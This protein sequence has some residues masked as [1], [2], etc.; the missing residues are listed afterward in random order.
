MDAC[1]DIER[2]DTSKSTK[3]GYQSK[4]A[5]KEPDVALGTRAKEV[6]V[7]SSFSNVHCEA[8]VLTLSSFFSIS[9]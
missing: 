5:S 8:N 2:I 3:D 9:S 7:S 6:P 1:G 4:E